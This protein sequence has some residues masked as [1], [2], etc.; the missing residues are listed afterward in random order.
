[1]TMCDAVFDNPLDWTP[2]GLRRDL[3]AL[4]RWLDEVPVPVPIFI[5]V[6]YKDYWVAEHGSDKL[7]DGYAW[8]EPMPITE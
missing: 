3:E 7:P 1:M 6:G 2:P 4:A 5:P 8:L